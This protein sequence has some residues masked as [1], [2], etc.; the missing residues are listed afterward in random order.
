M[1]KVALMQIIALTDNGHSAVADNASNPPKQVLPVRIT[2]FAE[3]FY[4]MRAE[5]PYRALLGGRVTTIDGVPFDEILR[6][7]ETLQG[8]TEPFRRENAATLIVEQDILYGLGIAHDPAASFWTVLQPDG[9]FVTVLLHASPLRRPF[10]VNL[11]WLSPEPMKGMGRE[12]LSYSPASGHLPQSLQNYD[13]H[14][15]LIHVPGSCAVYIRLHYILNA[16]GQKIAPFLTATEAALRAHPPCA[17]IVDLRGNPGGNYDY[18]RRLA[19]DLPKLVAANGPIYVLTD[20]QTFSAAILTAA[21]LKDAGGDRTRIV[22]EPVG[23]RLAFYS[24]GPGGCLPNS[25][26]CVHYQI[27]KHDLKKLCVQRDCWWR[28]WFSPVRVESLQP[29]QP[30]PRRFA[31]WNAG[32]DAAYEAAIEAISKSGAT[33]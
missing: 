30:V 18:T 10:T 26:L 6:R 31:D 9:H 16:Y 25:K 8:G 1:L 21:F 22:G 15:A 19:Y 20:S 5:E 12:W 7:L 24:E 33:R 3:G 29:D 17:A 4:V 14:F 11:R 32:H 27:G 28:D 23:D 2:P 13:N